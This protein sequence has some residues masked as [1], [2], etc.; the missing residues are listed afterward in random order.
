MVVVTSPE[1]TI[2]LGA[3]LVAI[4]WGVSRGIEYFNDQT[5]AQFSALNTQLGVSLEVPERKLFNLEWTY[6]A[7]KG[8]YLGRHLHIAIRNMDM[9]GVAVPHTVI[10]IDTLH[11]GKTL[12]ISAET[13]VSTLKKIVGKQ[14][15]ITGDA[16]FDRRFLIKSNDNGFV[17]KLLDDDI[18]DILKKEVFLKMGKISLKHSQMFYEEQVVVNTDNERRRIENIILVMYMIA[19]RMEYMRE[20]KI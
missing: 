10:T 8:A 5:I 6:P 20:R 13:L 3:C 12:E 18:R 14:D 1:M 2:I 19:K 9:A 11:S 16:E 7:L 17:K 4:Y 15:V